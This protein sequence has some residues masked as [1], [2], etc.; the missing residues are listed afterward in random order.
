MGFPIASKVIFR[1]ELRELV[2][3][4]GVK[5]CEDA[6]NLTSLRARRRSSGDLEQ[7][8]GNRR[9]KIFCSSIPW[10]R[11]GEQT[12]RKNCGGVR[13]RP[14]PKKFLKQSTK[15]ILDLYAGASSKAMRNSAAGNA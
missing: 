11:G 10:G 15:K 9:R 3:N 13:C 7:P 5:R 2:P 12:R 6:R 8:P 1:Q 4:L 14:S